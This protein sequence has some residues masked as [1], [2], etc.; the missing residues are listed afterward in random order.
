VAH[1]FVITASLGVVG[2]MNE[3]PLAVEH[4][5]MLVSVSSGESLASAHS[6][7][8][9]VGIAIIAAAIATNGLSIVDTEK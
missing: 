1:I 3:C 6:A 5:E 2:G 8:C 4:A 9:T 7:A